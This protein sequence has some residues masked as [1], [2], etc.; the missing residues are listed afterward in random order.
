MRGPPPAFADLKVR[1]RLLPAG[2]TLIRLLYL[3]VHHSIPS[4]GL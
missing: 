2:D 1:N 4:G 3:P